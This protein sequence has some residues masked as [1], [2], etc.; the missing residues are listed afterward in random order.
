MRLLFRARTSFLLPTASHF[1]EICLKM[2]HIPVLD[3]QWI[4]SL[5]IWLTEFKTFGSIL[6][7]PTSSAIKADD[8]STKQCPKHT[9]CSLSGYW[10]VFCLELIREKCRCLLSWRQ[11]IPALIIWLC[12]CRSDKNEAVTHRTG[13]RKRDTV[14]KK[15][16]RTKRGRWYEREFKGK[17]KLAREQKTVYVKQMKRR[18]CHRIYGRMREATWYKGMESSMPMH[19]WK[20]IEKKYVQSFLWS[21]LEQS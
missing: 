4:N 21:K 6:Q 12:E 8:L 19:V 1:Q 3:W 2:R 18:I 14:T 17:R 10:G 16:I 11:S 9:D 15:R 7:F 13:G 20:I 5:V